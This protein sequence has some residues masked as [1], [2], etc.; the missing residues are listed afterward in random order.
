MNDSFSV[1]L[2]PPLRQLLSM[3]MLG[4][5]R[6]TWKKLSSPRRAIPTAVV[7][8]LLL[9]YCLQI[10]IALAFND[11]FSSVP[12]ES[13]APVG[14]LGIMLLKL[15]AVCI[16]RT[17]SGAGFRHEEIHCLLGGPFS[18]QQVRLYRICGHAVS[19]FFTSVFAAI[20][21]RFHVSS[22][23]AA[24]S[25]AYL[26]MMF[27]YLIYT[28]VA[29]VAMYV[30]DSTYRLM[31]NV[32]CG[33]ALAVL[34]YVL[35]RVA[36]LGVSNLQFLRAFGN[37]AIVLSQTPIG[38]VLV[39]PFVAFTNIVV[40]ESVGQWTVWFAFGLLLNYIALQLVMRLEVY[41][42]R[43][44][45]ERE[46]QL[47]EQNRNELTD[48]SAALSLVDADRFA[49]PLPQLF[50]AGPII[51][52]QFRALGKLKGGLGW[53]LIPLG[54][55]FAAGGYLAFDPDEGALQTIAVIV[56]LT[57]VF[58]PG[59]LPF[60]FRGDLK[61]L[62]AL[63]MM[64]MSPLPVVLGQ[65]VVPVCLLSLFQLLA[66]STLVLHDTKLASSVL[67]TFCFLLPTNTIIIA[68][69]NLIFLLYPYRIAEFDA[70]ATV[71]RVVMLMAKFCVIFCAGLLAL[72]FGLGVV[73]L[74]MATKSTAFGDWVASMSWPLTITGQMLALTAIA[75]LVVRTTCWAY[76]RFD[77]SED[78]PV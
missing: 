46:R 47:F 28:A 60:D 11:S 20:F 52:R 26:A 76:R 56:V 72:L 13:I 78:M 10:Y 32:V 67:L 33:A 4:K 31:R 66:L 12:I 37:E 5:V 51:W 17:K 27:T 64:P 36:L 53:L 18:Q 3:Q 54:L 16:D 7:G 70:Q 42:V 14:M 8:I 59:L 48:P 55:A 22:F 30:S 21:F 63:K 45:D 75:C 24:L 2:V 50:G 19:I 68:L 62:T 77:L 34:G 29:I 38:Q 74:K 23:T 73:G 43:Q 71:R 25:G 39:A 49:K 9:L 6:R 65:L 15:L 35:Y 44:T 57:S 1:Q 58:L 69:E 61:G 41:F 40:A